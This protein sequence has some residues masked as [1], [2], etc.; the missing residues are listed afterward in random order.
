MNPNVQKLLLCIEGIWLNQKPAPEPI[1]P[2]AELEVL[3]RKLRKKLHGFTPEM[4]AGIDS[5]SMSGWREGLEEDLP[6]PALVLFALHRVLGFPQLDPGDKGR[7][8][9][10]CSVAGQPVVFRD[11][12]FGF[13]ILVAPGSTLEKK[14]IVLPLKGALRV[15]EEEFLKPLAAE[16]VQQGHVTIVNRFGEFQSRYRYLRE[17]AAEAY[18][19]GVIQPLP[20]V[21]LQAGS[22][23]GLADILNQSTQAKRK[24]FFLSTAMVDA[25]FSFLEHR[26]I[27][28]RAFTGVP[29]GPG[30]FDRL[31][32]SNWEG[33]LASVIKLTSTATGQRLLSQLKRIKEKVRNPFAHGGMENDGGSVFV[34]VPQFGALPANFSK[35]KD[36]VRFKHLPIEAEDHAAMGEVFDGLDSLLESGSLAGPHRFVEACVDPAFDPA[37]MREYA[38]AL[39]EGAEAIDAYVDVWSREWE[40]HQNADY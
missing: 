16:Q 3:R 34:H 19:G 40:R 5:W 15:L 38:G 14:R 8:A 4:P 26:L 18:Q 1:E 39:R 29:M 28:L 22:L 32:K 30:E 21:Q 2:A 33:K 20:P 35:I 36:S 31:V 10:G 9:V 7:W 37:E 23:S 11:R 24:G 13:E 25:Y 12:K 6:I 17:A 27:L